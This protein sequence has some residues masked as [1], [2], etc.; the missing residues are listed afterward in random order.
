M[1]FQLRLS[2]SVTAMRVAMAAAA[3]LL[4]AGCSSDST[5]LAADAGGDLTPTASI[6]GSPSASTRL[7]NEAV[8]GSATQAVGRVSTIQS[9]P[10]APV[11]AKPLASA[12]TRSAIV[13]PM[14]S[15]RPAYTAPATPSPQASL[16][17]SPP[18]PLSTGTISQPAA[19]AR[20]ANSGAWSAEGG[21]PIIVAQGETASML[22]N[23]YGVPTDSLLR[24]NG[25]SSASQVQPGARLVIPVYNGARSASTAP[26]PAA[27][28]ALRPA[29]PMRQAVHE[30]Q[31][32]PPASQT[33]PQTVSNEPQIA[34]VRAAAPAKVE[35]PATQ[36]VAATPPRAKEKLQFVK[37][38]EPAAKAA[39]VKVA[40][41]KPAKAVEAKPV[42]EAKP[43]LAKA[44]EKPA[45][46]VE[47]AKAE[48]KPEKPTKQQIADAKAGK[49]PAAEKAAPAVDRE[50]TT[51]SVD[52]A[53]AS[54]ADASD[55]PEFRWP[56]RGRVIQS[57]KPGANDGINIALPEGTSVKAAEGGTVAY[58]GSELKGYGNMVLIRHP[59][60]Y[61]SAYANNGDIAVKRGD[62]VTRGQTIAKSG[63]TG[64]VASPQLHFELRKGSTPVDPT[65]YLA[66][67]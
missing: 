62:K 8:G 31:P 58:A 18:A 52:P 5:R 26:K 2:C 4:M 11:G 17:A 66:G 3:A 19:I 44:T 60:G 57:F 46:P 28:T 43:A 29:A 23:R 63:A 41:A 51:A 42:K 48:T 7:R 10:L 14:A 39:P 30:P 32:A 55:K 56:A 61:V 47:T 9:T 64:N 1:R 35:K 45:K 50:T 65:G 36:K 25:F 24:T 40:E 27:S 53:A 16:R 12:A 34:P 37:G 59:N 22:A 33:S 54:V 13:K 20:P 6:P 67:L 21:T 38:P 49:K 15:A